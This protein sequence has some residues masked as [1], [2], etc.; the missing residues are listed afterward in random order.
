MAVAGVE[1]V[2]VVGTGV[3]VSV[4]W[5]GSGGEVGEALGCAGAVVLVAWGGIG[6]VGTGVAVALGAGGWV[7][8]G[9]GAVAVAG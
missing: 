6:C 4:A 7:A 3:L 8:L 9:G 5:A 1:G 2:C